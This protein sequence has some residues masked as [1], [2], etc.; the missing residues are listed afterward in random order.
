MIVGQW[1]LEMDSVQPLH[2]SILNKFTDSSMPNA[3]VVLF[4]ANDIK[5]V[6]QMTSF[7]LK[8]GG[9]VGLLAKVDPVAKL[10]MKNAG[11]VSYIF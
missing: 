3:I 7:D 10:A 1:T 8:V 11:L 2:A 9:S 6:S 5:V 4:N